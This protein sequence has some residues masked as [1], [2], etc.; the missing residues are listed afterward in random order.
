MKKLNILLIVLLFSSFFYPFANAKSDSIF[1]VKPIENVKV[2]Y[3]QNYNEYLNPDGSKAVD[4][5]YY[6]LQY[7]INGS[8][9]S[10]WDPVEVLSI[11]NQKIQNHNKYDVIYNS[12]VGGAKADIVFTPKVSTSYR[13]VWNV[14]GVKGDFEET[15]KGAIITGKDNVVFLDYSEA[16]DQ[17]GITPDVSYDKGDF[18]AVFVL[19]VLPLN[20]EFT[21]DP[22]IVVSYTQGNTN[23]VNMRNRHP[24]SNASASSIGQTF[25]APKDFNIGNVTF[26]MGANGNP[27]ANIYCV[28]Y[29]SNG[30]INVNSTPFG[31]ELARSAAFN[32]SV[33]T[34]VNTLYNFSFVGSNQYKCINGTQYAVCIEAPEVGDSGLYNFANYAAAYIDNTAPTFAGN[35]ATFANSAW[36]AVAGTDMYFIV[37]EV[38]FWNAVADFIDSAFNFFGISNYIANI[39]TFINGLSSEFNASLTRIV[40][41]FLE[42]FKVINEVYDFF[43]LWTGNMLDIVLDFSRFYQSIL[44]GT[45]QF[46]TPILSLG[47][48]WTLIGYDIWSDAVPLFLFILWIDSL[49]KRGKIVVGGE[50]QV[51][52]NDINTSINLISYFTG[53]FIYVVETIIARVYGLFDA[54]SGAIVV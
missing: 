35:F 52:L 37:Y 2:K 5:E 26:N 22:A 47:N 11:G 36:S 12:L 30:T 18:K 50:I 49:G 7:L 54:V 15:D 44:D 40:S 17:T 24:S 8:W 27:T 9:V 45:N 20:V 43:L 1:D 33:L 3:N 6:D 32:T 38:V 34:A 23:Y 16:F 48:I 46:I 10:L 41:L 29:A 4:R 21:L 31:S 14:E 25:I 53:V 39:T 19:G 42:Q 28:L 13:I 51:F